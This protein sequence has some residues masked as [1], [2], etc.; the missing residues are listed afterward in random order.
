VWHATAY[1]GERLDIAFRPVCTRVGT[2]YLYLDG[3]A[4]ASYELD[5]KPAAVG[6][7]E[8]RVE[9]APGTHAVRVVGRGRPLVDR[10]VA[11]REHE[12]TALRVRYPWRARKLSWILAVTTTA[13]A[14]QIHDGVGLTLAT[15]FAGARLRL[16]AEAGSMISDVDRLRPGPIG[17]G[18]PLIA[19]IGMYHVR[20]APLWHGGTLSLDIDPVALR[21][22]QVREASYFGIRAAATEA[23]GEA[24]S[25]LPV[26]LTR[27]S[28]WVH[29]EA[30][31]WPL[32]I[33]HYRAGTRDA[34]GVDHFD[35]RWGVGTFV[36]VT[37]GWRLL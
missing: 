13:R 6:E 11:I 17:P 29:L 37:G 3:D 21:Y 10:D 32:S 30:A 14:G 34:A 36:T 23:Y 27:D 4:G 19:L 2:L 15:G 31:L 20:Q 7:H 16:V 28:R 33:V 26:T 24:W 9:L 35:D 1:P 22:D 18:R 25:L 12:T 5:G 8:A